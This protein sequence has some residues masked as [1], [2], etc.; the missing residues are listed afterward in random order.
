MNHRKP[1]FHA[2][3]FNLIDDRF[4]ARDLVSQKVHKWRFRNRAD[5]LHDY[6]DGKACAVVNFRVRGATH[7]HQLVFRSIPPWRGEGQAPRFGVDVSEIHGSG[8]LADRHDVVMLVD[9]CEVVQCPQG[10]ISSSVW[11]EAPIERL[12]WLRE[13][14]ASRAER[15]VEFASGAGEGE[16]EVAE[17]AIAE[18][19]EPS[20]GGCSSVETLSQITEDTRGHFF[21]LAR[22]RL[23]KDDLVNVLSRI[24]IDIDTTGVRFVS[25]IGSDVP[26]EVGDA[27]LCAP[28]GEPCGS[29]GFIQSG[30][31]NSDSQ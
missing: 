18:A 2:S 27:R 20:N 25:V 23:S 26:I 8:V 14:L 28:Y 5:P 24:R 6:I 4:H 29:E 13:S 11:I 15:L 30:S 12:D 22:H 31:H 16:A 17:S 3:G 19:M 9:S 10:V 7:K 21:D 1:N